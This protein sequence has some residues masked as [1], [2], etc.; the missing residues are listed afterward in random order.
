MQ[1][2]VW[3]NEYQKRR[4]VSG[5][6]E[7]QASVKDFLRWLRRERGIPLEHLRVLDLGCGNGKNSNYI[8]SLDMTNRAIGIDISE[9]ALTEARSHAYD[10]EVEEQVSF[11]KHSIGS[12]FPF[13]NES[14]DIVLDVTSSNS[15]NEKERTIY[16]SETARVLKGASA[17]PKDPTNT[18]GGYFFVRALCKDGDTNAQHLLKMNPG[19][20]RDTYRM[21]ELGLIERVFS[22]EDFIETYTGGAAPL[23]TLHHIEKE[24]H[25]TKFAGR[26]YKRNFWIAYL[27][28]I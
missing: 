7:P 11:S 4:L 17:S 15:L 10:M 8:C 26:S 5:S 24:T 13:Q 3:E 28:K 25:Y 6:I 9:T 27:Q 23:F 19:P 20:E 18:T 1:E 22:R 2:H 14:F 21:P 16:M 12:S